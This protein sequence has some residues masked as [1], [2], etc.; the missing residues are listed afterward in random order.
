[1]ANDRTVIGVHRID[2]D[3]RLDLDAAVFEESEL[4]PGG[5]CLVVASPEG[6]VTVMP[7]TEGFSPSPSGQ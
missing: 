3:G 6:G 5:Q 1:M 4:E 2:E 7:V